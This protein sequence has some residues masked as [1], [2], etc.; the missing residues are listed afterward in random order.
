MFL[1]YIEKQNHGK[2]LFD[3]DLISSYSYL[4]LSLTLAALRKL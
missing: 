2:T 4:S 1:I 3:I